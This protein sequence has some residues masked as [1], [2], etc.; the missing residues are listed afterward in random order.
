MP[1]GPGNLIIVSAAALASVLFGIGLLLWGDRLNLRSHQAL[2]TVAT[3]L[4]TV[5]IAQ[6]TSNTAAL[7]LASFYVFIACDAAF[8]FTW[9]M[10]AAQITFAVACCMTVLASRPDLPWWSGLIAS[11][12]T[13]AV[14]GVVGV[15]G[16]LASDADVDVLTG[17]LNRR[18]FDRVLNHEIARVPRSGL[19]PALVL[20]NVDRFSSIND[21]HGY[22][23]GDAVLRDIAES[24]RDILAPKQV[25]ARYGGDE[26][27]LLLPD[28]NEQGAIAITE[29]FRTA[30]SMGCSAG[31]TSWQP[32]ESASFL[33]SR[34]D[35]GL[36]RAKQ[37]GRNRTV[38]ESSRRPPLAVELLEALARENLDVHYQPIVS[39]D[40]GKA[41][42]VG[43]E[44]LVRWT[45]E[46]QPDATPD[47]IVRVAEENDLISSLDKFVMNRACHDAHKLQ[48]VFPDR[49]LILNV[50]VSGLELVDNDYVSHIDDVLRA[51]G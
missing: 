39:L 45:S 36:Y 32:G 14:G 47:E 38:L 33:V 22:R 5:A 23:A 6:S 2:V 9:M 31:V 21:Q 16:R 19:R 12:A 18:G 30:I 17:L 1:E 40:G 20:F 7:S 15:L 44:A 28:T 29:R 24:W 27:A 41:T 26:F 34:A 50:N 37:A 25:L 13:F 51:S 4:I 10:A 42:T 49:P 3:L 8:F 35:V 46:T 43:V 48:E 11:G